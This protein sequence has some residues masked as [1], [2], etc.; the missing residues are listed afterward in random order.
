MDAQTIVQRKS[1]L[2]FSRLDEAYLAIDAQ[3]GYCYGLNATAGAVWDLLHDPLSVAALCARL[4]QDYRTDEETC[5]RDVT[6]LLSEMSAAGLVQTITS[7][8]EDPSP[9]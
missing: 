8:K 4:R 9:C 5:R 2:E 7:G 6:A 1:G 3:A